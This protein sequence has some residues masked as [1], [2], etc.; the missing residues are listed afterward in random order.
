MM[1]CYALC[2]LGIWGDQSQTQS[3]P[4][5]LLSGA[6][7]KQICHFTLGCFKEELEALGENRGGALEGLFNA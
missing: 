4:V 3:C 5:E 7:D 1:I 6:R 2:E